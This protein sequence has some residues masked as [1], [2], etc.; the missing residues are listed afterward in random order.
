MINANQVATIAIRL[1]ALHLLF[2]TVIEA[3]QTV[4]M[5]REEYGGGL[6]FHALLPAVLLAA[7]ALFLLLQTNLVAR[8]LVRGAESSPIPSLDTRQ[9]VTAAFSLAGVVFVV[10]GL[11]SLAAVG[12]HLLVPANPLRPGVPAEALA[13]NATFALVKSLLGLWLFF[14]SRQILAFMDRLRPM[15]TPPSDADA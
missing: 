15:A 5:A 9:L 4:S 3:E 2:A 8:F 11:A 13:S 10:S 1:Y 14:G 7:I 6:T 12:A